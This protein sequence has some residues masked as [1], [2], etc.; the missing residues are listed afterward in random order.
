MHRK[1]LLCRDAEVLNV[2]VS[3]GDADRHQDLAH[4]KQLLDKILT[5][6]LH[7]LSASLLC[8]RLLLGGGLLLGCWLLLGWRRLFRRLRLLALGWRWL[9]LL[10]ARGALRLGSRR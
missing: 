2:L 9:G 10:A 4:L 1:V 5:I 7:L 8:R 3:H 6:D